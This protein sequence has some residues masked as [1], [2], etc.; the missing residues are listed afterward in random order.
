M[1]NFFVGL[2]MAA[3][4]FS[5]GNINYINYFHMVF[6]TIQQDVMQVENFCFKNSN[7]SVI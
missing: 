5:T 2:V 3:D 7:F 4:N 1:L 6:L